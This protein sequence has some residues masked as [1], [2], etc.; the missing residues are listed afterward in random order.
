M[1]VFYIVDKTLT[2]RTHHPDI[3][4][5]FHGALSTSTQIGLNISYDIFNVD[6]EIEQC[7]RF[8]GQ[9]NCL[10]ANLAS[11]IVLWKQYTIQVKSIQFGL[12]QIQSVLNSGRARS[13]QA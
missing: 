6:L 12:K 7:C 4:D 9:V 13:T 11:S 5:Q 2:S 1:L 3:K 10:I 8:A